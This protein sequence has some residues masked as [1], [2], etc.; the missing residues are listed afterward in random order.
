[1]DANVASI[2]EHQKIAFF[3][4]F[5]AANIANGVRVGLLSNKRGRLLFVGASKGKRDLQ[6]FQ[7]FLQLIF[8]Q[9]ES[10]GNDVVQFGIDQSQPS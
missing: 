8:G 4:E 7:R 6:S 5:A 1:M 10:R 2:A 3:A 9:R